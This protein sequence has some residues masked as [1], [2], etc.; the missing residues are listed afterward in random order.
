MNE[1][2][3]EMEYSF[4]Q[5]IILYCLKKLNGERTI[6]SIYH[7]LNG[8]KSSQTIQDAHLFHLTA[9]FQTDTNITR[10]YLEN[11]VSNFSNDNY[12][13]KVSE[14]HYCITARGRKPFIKIISSYTDSY[15]LKWMEI[16][17]DR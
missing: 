17:A 13:E 2:G 5:T 15:S 11:T 3:D 12:I 10:D 6:Y 7:L 1:H 14:Q 8:K 9:F 16:S 4:L